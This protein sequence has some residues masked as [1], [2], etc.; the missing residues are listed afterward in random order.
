MELRNYTPHDPLVF[1]SGDAAVSLPQLGNARCTEQVIQNGWWDTERT[2]PRYAIHYGDVVGLPD[3]EP[4]V[5][6]VVSQ[7]AAQAALNRPDVAFPIL[8]ERDETGTI[9]GFRGLA[10]S[11]GAQ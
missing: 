9:R 7:L 2:L 11:G 3:P 1:L 10:E 8:L 5:L 4:G 6:L